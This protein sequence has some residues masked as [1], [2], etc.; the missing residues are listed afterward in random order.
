MRALS[1]GV[2]AACQIVTTD[3]LASES[4]DDPPAYAPVANVSKVLTIAA[5]VTSFRDTLVTA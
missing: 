1:W 2:I 3:R 4:I 5:S